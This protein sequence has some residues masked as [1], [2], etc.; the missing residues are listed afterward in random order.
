MSPREFLREL[1]ALAPDE[2]KTLVLLLRDCLAP[3]EHALVGLIEAREL[4]LKPVPYGTRPG[5]PIP[6]EYRGRRRAWL[7]VA[8]TISG[9]TRDGR[10][11]WRCSCE[12]YEAWLARPPTQR[13]PG[14]A[15]AGP[16]PANDIRGRWTADGSLRARGVAVRR[17]ER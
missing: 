1:A 16:G 13:S 12:A 9:A 5:A 8:P 17:S 11:W 3:L 7:R 6:A 14:S 2:R 15:T 4:K 10:R